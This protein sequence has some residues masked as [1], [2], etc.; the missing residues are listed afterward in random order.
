MKKANPVLKAASTTI[1][2]TFNTLIMAFI[3]FALAVVQT[4]TC[5]AGN[6]WN[7]ATVTD[8]GAV[9]GFAFSFVPR[10]LESGIAM[11][12]VNKEIWISDIMEGFY[13][14]GEWLARAVDMSAWVEF[15]TIN[16]TEAGVDPNVLI[17]NTTYPVATAQ[18][19]DANLPLPLDT[20]DSENTLIRNVEAMEAAADK[21]ASVIRQHQ[22]AII[23]K[24]RQKAAHAYAPASDAAYTPVLVTSGAADATAGGTKAAT[25]ADLARMAK[26]FNDVDISLDGRQG[27][28]CPLHLQQ[29]I[30]QD[31]ALYKQFMDQKEGQPLRYAGFD[32]F[33]FSS[34]ARYNTSTNAKVAFGAAA[35]GTD[36]VGSSVFFQKDEVMRADGTWD[37]FLRE[38][39]PEQRGDIIGFQKRGLYLPIRNK[40][41]GSLF[42]KV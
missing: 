22:N 42:S 11:A 35:A 1:T 10:S 8:I 20:Y 4:Q 6:E 39:D 2:L 12:G 13:P 37:M 23:K 36:S 28:L 19:V 38:K 21:R 27:V 15:N 30:G 17:N 9:A 18:R 3:F 29:L 16:L 24:T 41:I 33:T 7:I 34:T 5:D 25:L 31:T 14:A 26:R 40:A 32:L